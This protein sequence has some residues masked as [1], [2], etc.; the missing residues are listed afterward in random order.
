[1]KNRRLT[2]FFEAVFVRQPARSR[3][4]RVAN[5]LKSL[6]SRRLSQP[7][8]RL[9]TQSHDFRFGWT[10]SREYRPDQRGSPAKRGSHILKTACCSVD[11]AGCGRRP[12]SIDLV[13]RPLR[14]I[15]RVGRGKGRKT[16]S[17]RLR[18]SERPWRASSFFGGSGERLNPL[19]AETGT[20]HRSSGLPAVPGAGSGTSDSVADCRR[21]SVDQRYYLLSAE[22]VGNLQDTNDRADRILQNPGN[23]DGKRVPLRP[24]RTRQIG[25]G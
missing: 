18:A 25:D 13:R 19:M 16:A 17:G 24:W 21:P 14:P 15:E 1:M 11:V 23:A 6:V 8:A 5:R 3:A 22:L 12:H 20:C 2:P 10:L 7:E 4:G 9:V